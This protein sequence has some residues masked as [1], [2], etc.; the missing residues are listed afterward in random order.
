MAVGKKTSAQRQKKLSDAL[1]TRLD[2]LTESL[3]VAQVADKGIDLV[4]E[5]KELHAILRAVREGDKQGEADKGQVSRIILMWGEEPSPP[6]AG[7]V[8]SCVPTK[9]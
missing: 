5:I 4:K 9:K 1:E 2:A 3:A 8:P 7:A 6:A